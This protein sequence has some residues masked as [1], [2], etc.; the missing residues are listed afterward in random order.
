MKKLSDDQLLANSAG[1]VAVVLNIF[2]GLGTGYIYQRR[3]KAYWLTGLISAIW[4]YIG[5]FIQLGVD[6]TDPIS[7]QIDPWGFSGILVITCIT[8]L[9]AGLSVKRARESTLNQRSSDR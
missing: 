2:P 1:W 7:Q 3:W 4:L 9:E 6:S 5:L 8:S